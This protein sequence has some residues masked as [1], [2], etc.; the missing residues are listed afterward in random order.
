MAQMIDHS[1]EWQPEL[2]ELAARRR[3][4]EQLG[5]E[6]AVRKHHD[7][8]RK[9]IRERIAGVVDAGSFQE[10]GRLTGQGAYD[11]ATLTGVTPAPYV[12]GLARIDG[13]S[14]A[15]GGEDFTVRGGTSWSGDRK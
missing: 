8:G 7:Q 11:G 15:I 2:D 3:H 13:R 9:T 5:G 6:S 14:V 10:V 1:A 4:A 12:M